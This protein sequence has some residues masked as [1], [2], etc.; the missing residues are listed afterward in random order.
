[1]TSMIDRVMNPITRGLEMIFGGDSAPDHETE[2]MPKWL[3]AVSYFDED[4]IYWLDGQYVGFAFVGSP[5]A[6][7]GQ[8]AAEKLAGILQGQLPT[9]T[10]MQFILWT[11]PDMEGTLVQYA[12]ERVHATTPFL[13]ETRDSFSEF[14]RGGASKSVVQGQ[15]IRLRDVKL[16]ITCKVPRASNEVDGEDLLR[17]TELRDTIGAGL[18]SVGFKMELMKPDKYLR[19]MQTIFN[20]SPD[21]AWR[22]APKSQ[23]SPEQPLTSQILDFDNEVRIDKEGLWFGDHRVRVLSPKRYPQRAQF[24]MAYSYLGEVLT[25]ARGLRDPVLMAMNLWFRDRESEAGMIETES[26]YLTNQAG[27]GMSRFR[28][29]I[30]RQKQSFDI[31]VKQLGEGDRI[32]RCAF[33]MAIISP[34]DRSSIASVAAA[35]A[36]MREFGFH[37]LEDRYIAAPMFAHL[38]PFG[39][40]VDGA[41]SIRRWRRLTTRAV[42]PLLPIMSEWRGTG[43]P[44]LLTISRNGQLMS[45]SNWDSETSFNVA[46]AAESGSGKSFL[47]QTLAVN[48]RMTNGRMWIIDKGKSYRNIV[49]LLGGQRMTF[50]TDSKLCLNPFTKIESYD[51]EEDM[52]FSLIA[53][54]AA[55]NDKLTDYQVAAGKRVMREVWDAKRHLMQVDDLAVALVAQEDPRLKDMG[56]QLTPFTKRGAH[57]WLF[58][59][60]NNYEATNPV[61][62]L[63]LDDLEGKPQ[64]QRV[65]LLQLMFQI[66]RDMLRL[67]RAIQKY[68]LIDEAWELLSGNTP[69]GGSDPVAEFVGKAYRQFRKGNGS[70]FTI[71]Q[72][73]AD[74][75]RNEVTRAIWE[76]SPH[77]WLLGQRG[78]AINSCQKEGWLAIDDHGYR[79]LR[80]VHTVKGEYSEIFMHTPFG[81]GVG[82]LIVPPLARKLFSTTATD[83]S[84]INKLREGGMSLTKAVEQIAREDGFVSE[85][86]AKVA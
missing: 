22:M 62:L 50:G 33:G 45:L 51:D 64:L 2:V 19:F 7:A 12:M 29:Q 80:G 8:S 17:V 66:R 59:G 26:M 36:Y 5:L 68:L 23:Y 74:F 71:T 11:S 43:T 9:N 27:Q 86:R 44:T 78:E 73:I 32:I 67:D 52:I 47:A 81:Y 53:A 14:Y 42:V 75:Q 79:L 41:P 28:P 38:V 31:A 10:V 30:A 21:A 72:S 20:W 84:R 58:N 6:G 37:M 46:I 57:G 60:P 69:G 49:E 54:M 3:Q 76:N 24:G 35:K 39:T 85:P 15:D 48:A 1:M 65:V 25:G 55:I 40:D 13:R 77:K 34:N 63:E 83:V 61:I 4:S 56:E 18:K 16:V 82:R 70:A